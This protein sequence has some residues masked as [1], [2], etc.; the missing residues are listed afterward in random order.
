MALLKS[1]FASQAAEIDRVLASAGRP[2]L[3]VV[4]LPMIGRKSF[5]TV[6][7]DPVTAEVLAYMPLDSF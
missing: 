7:L 1:R 6:F 5:W 3:S 2:P 4:Y